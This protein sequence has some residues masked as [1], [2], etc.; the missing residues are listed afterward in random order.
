MW[1]SE[2]RVAALEGRMGL[3]EA[4][5][6]ALFERLGE[7]RDG[8]LEAL[9]AALALSRECMASLTAVALREHATITPP[10]GEPPMPTEPP[11]T[12]T[13]AAPLPDDIR[14]LI[15]E[16]ARGNRPLRRQLM[17]DA[18]Q[19]LEDGYEPMEVLAK[20]RQGDEAEVP[21]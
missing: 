14:E 20:I 11:P 17:A 7:E 19:M 10:L 8:L 15:D 2:Q 4:R 1:A 12:H 3:L 5:I 16:F 18:Y 21:L 6:D 13:H 9:Q